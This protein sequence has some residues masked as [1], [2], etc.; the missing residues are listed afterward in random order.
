MTDRTL[1]RLSAALHAVMGV[2]TLVVTPPILL[3]AAADGEF[4][5]IGGVRVLGGGAF[6]LLGF[7]SMLALGWLFAAVGALEA[8]AA[9]QLWRTRRV[10]WTLAAGLV[11]VGLPFWIGFALPLWPPVA[12]LRV[13]LAWLGRTGLR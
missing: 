6:E 2:L 3:K 13:V 9:V 11:P 12:A 8:A 5:V 1:L 7:R 4:P 10:G